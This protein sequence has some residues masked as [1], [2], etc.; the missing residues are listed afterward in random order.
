VGELL[1]VAVADDLRLVVFAEIEDGAERKSTGGGFDNA[2][3]ADD[4]FGVISFVVG[5]D[6]GGQQT[7]HDA[8]RYHLQDVH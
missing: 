2:P 7:H 4:Q 8:R 3:L 6:S 5:L 1:A